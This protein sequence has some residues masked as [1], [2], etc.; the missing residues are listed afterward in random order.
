MPKLQMFGRAGCA[1]LRKRVLLARR[2]GQ[3]LEEPKARP[4]DPTPQEV[5]GAEHSAVGIIRHPRDQAGQTRHDVLLVLPQFDVREPAE[6]IRHLSS[7]QRRHD[8]VD[9]AA[10]AVFSGSCS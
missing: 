9:I 5:G 7:Q 6:D 3:L 10:V 8:V 2:P 4:T 1:L